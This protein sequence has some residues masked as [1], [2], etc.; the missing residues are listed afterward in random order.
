[1]E[2]K[3]RP[4]STQN[5]KSCVVL[6]SRW[7]REPLRPRGGGSASKLQTTNFDGFR[8]WVAML[9]RTGR[10]R[11]NDSHIAARKSRACRV[12]TVKDRCRT[13]EKSV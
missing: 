1:M 13:E 10:R 11:Q 2:G 9:D 12:Q 5:S 8:V 3:I 6:T 7:S 4:L